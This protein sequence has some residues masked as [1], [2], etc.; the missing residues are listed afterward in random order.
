MGFEFPFIG[1]FTLSQDSRESFS[2]K[3][4]FENE[5]MKR[6]SQIAFLWKTKTKELKLKILLKM[7]TISFENIIPRLFQRDVNVGAQNLM[8]LREVGDRRHRL[9]AGDE[10]LLGCP[11]TEQH[12]RV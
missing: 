4:W 12:S 8:T 1:H 2:G 5:S 6:I 10:S 11:D 9:D 7:G 3:D